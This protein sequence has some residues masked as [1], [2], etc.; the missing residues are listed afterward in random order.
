MKRSIKLCLAAA[1]ILFV[2]GFV[3][4]LTGAVMGGRSE[5]DRYFEAGWDDLT[6]RWDN[7]AEGDVFGPIR[8]TGEG[9]HIGGENG[10]HVD[11][12]GVDIGGEH[13]IH[14]GHHSEW[15]HE[16]RQQLTQSGELAGIT[17]V[18]I[19]VDCGDVWIQE[20]DGFSASLSWNLNNYTMGYLV[21]DGTLIIDSDSWGNGK[22]HDFV[23]DCKVIVTVPAGA[24]LEKLK[25]STDFGDIEV[26]AAVSVKEA[27]L[28]T[29]LGDV[30][31]R[32][33]QARELEAESD[34]G[35][36]TV[37]VP[38]ECKGLSYSLST[39]LGEVQFNGQVQK[40]P[41]VV[42]QHD[43]KYYVEATSSLGNVNLEY[44]G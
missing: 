18:E 8:V 34:L 1:G 44:M 29:D 26:D 7:A 31:C 33:L 17:A 37:N 12:S 25:A 13:G 6:A 21:E 41:T 36:V 3:L 38:A 10:I 14:V 30:T 27:E 35:D 40:N 42:V 39:D 4:H 28:S 23:I 32:G 24:E 43:E 2:C 16:G 22:N 20:G 5:S 19:S 11:S 9:V 15:E